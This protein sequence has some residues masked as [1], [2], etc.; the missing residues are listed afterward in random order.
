[1]V[2]FGI[3][4][5]S[6]YD[7]NSHNYVDNLIESIWSQNIKDYEI[8]C[9]GDYKI[10]NSNIKCIEV[11]NE[12]VNPISVKLNTIIDNSTKDYICFLRDY[13]QLDKNWWKG[14][15]KFGFDWDLAM[16]VIL[17]HKNERFLDWVAWCD[18]I[19]PRKWRQIEKWCPEG[20]DVDGSPFLPT[21]DY[22]KTHFMYISGAYWLGS[23]SF[24][25]KHKFGKELNLGDAEDVNWFNSFRFDK[26]S[27][28][29]NKYSL[30]RMQKQKDTPFRAEHPYFE[31][32]EY[33]TK[34]L[35]C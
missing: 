7:S 27:Y 15:E 2:T 12:E 18:P 9:V 4:N 30:T 28:K 20:L 1:M 16:N 8:I 11:P 14:W 3:C 6:Q 33:C 23:K 22:T 5:S 26:F 31:S 13:H 17:N 10:N 32:Y 21:Y 19:N 35:S 24:M 29:M 25:T 34:E